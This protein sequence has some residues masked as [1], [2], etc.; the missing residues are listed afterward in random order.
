MVRFDIWKEY[1]VLRYVPLHTYLSLL[2]TYLF[3][4]TM[5][6]E[7]PKENKLCLL[8]TGLYR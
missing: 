7:D 8:Q 1:T 3:Q 2:V 6:L 4:E 5:L